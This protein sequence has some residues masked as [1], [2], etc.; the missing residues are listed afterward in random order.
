MCD[1]LEFFEA[2]QGALHWSYVGTKLYHKDF[3]KMADSLA[4]INYTFT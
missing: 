4:V 1:E 3:D 2:P